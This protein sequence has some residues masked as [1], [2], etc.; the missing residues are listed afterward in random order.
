MGGRERIP[1]PDVLSWNLCASDV[2][3]HEGRIKYSRA[4]THYH[5]YP[6]SR[7]LDPQC[8]LY[9]HRD[10][11]YITDLH[12]CGFGFKNTAYAP[13]SA[14]FLRLD[15]LLRNPGERLAKMRRY[16]TIKPPSTWKFAYHYL[17]D[18]FPAVQNPAPFKVRDFDALINSLPEPPGQSE[19]PAEGE[20]RTAQLAASR[21]LRAWHL[22]NGGFFRRNLNRAAV[23]VLSRK[24][25]A[26]FL[27]TSA[28]F[29]RHQTWVPRRLPSQ[30]HNF[31]NDLYW[32]AS[33]RAADKAAVP[34][35]PQS[36]AEAS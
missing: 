7:L 5:S 24:P 2:Y 10:V 12:S 18:L 23:R 25:I 13:E 1:A 34:E 30:L 17:P 27:C 16:E 31:G 11:T 14:F 19:M 33:L 36:P 6:H 21:Y 3:R 35:A 9:R 28:G 4:K 22:R 26:E 29:L 8:R 32:Q 15:A 20:L